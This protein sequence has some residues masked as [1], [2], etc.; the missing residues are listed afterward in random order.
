[1]AGS[2]RAAPPRRLRWNEVEAHLDRGEAA[3]AYALCG[4]EMLLSDEVQ[5]LLSRR[6]VEGE[7]SRM[8]TDRFQAP[9]SG[10]GSV[11]QAVQQTPLFSQKRL[12][13]YSQFDGA[14]RSSDQEKRAWLGYLESPAP[15]TCLIVR[16]QLTSRELERKGT[17]FAESLRRMVVVDVWHPF[18]RD[19][20]QWVVRH[21]ATVG[22]K[23]RPDAAQLL[24]GHVGPDLLA[25]RQELDKLSLLL[26]AETSAPKELDLDVLSDLR[27]RGLQASSWECI[28]ALVEGRT[29]EAVLGLS[30]AREEERPTGL[31][32]KLQ[33]QALRKALDEGREAVWG[34]R[35]LK[36]CYQWERDLK[37]G[38]WAGS[39]DALAFEILFL[40]AHRR[41]LAV[42][43]AREK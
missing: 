40:R 37:R 27:R 41:R 10:I 24:V 13:V 26:E 3:P 6:V 16:T 36:D 14:A 5:G 4:P 30:S 12:V 31:A 17:F 39:L 9:E 25:L 11:L 43:S 2:R 19:A 20:V 32:W 18:P 42:G 7:W 35:L 15:S 21:G 1:M 38:R 33:Y 34:T 8:N 23:V 22:L 29:L 28:G